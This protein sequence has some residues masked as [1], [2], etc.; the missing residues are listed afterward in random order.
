L[1]LGHA[2]QNFLALI[3]LALILGDI[4]ED[5][6]ERFGDTVGGLL[7]ATFGNIVGVHSSYIQKLHSLYSHLSMQVQ[8]T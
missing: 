5:L 6:A 1:H 7:N 4:T 3:P 2:A 8:S